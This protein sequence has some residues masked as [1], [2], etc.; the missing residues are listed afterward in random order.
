MAK[1]TE[2]EFL[3]DIHMEFMDTI[4]DTSSDSGSLSEDELIITEKDLEDYAETPLVIRRTPR[5]KAVSAQQK[6]EDKWLV[7]LM[8]IASILCLGIIGY[9]VY[10]L[11]FFL[12]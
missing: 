4:P 12:K 3:G 5:K 10:W 8:A 9:L 7:T 2:Q 6:R 1:D 11:E